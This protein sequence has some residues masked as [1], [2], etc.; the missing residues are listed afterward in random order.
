MYISIHY[1]KSIASALNTVVLF[2][3]EPPIE[4]VNHPFNAKPDLVAF[5]SVPIADPLFILLDD[6]SE[7]PP[8]ALN[9]IVIFSTQ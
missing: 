7:D 9:V 1:A 3:Y 8:F 5:G 2:T 6:S 4:D